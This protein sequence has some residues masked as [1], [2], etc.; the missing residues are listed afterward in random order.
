MI[1]KTFKQFKKIIIA[2]VGGTILL[3]GIA[4]LVLPGPA[5]IVIP[6]GLSILATEFIWAKRIFEKFKEKMNNLKQ[7]VNGNN[8]K[9]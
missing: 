4:M 2:I 1:I 8:K 5:I 7:K 3:I 6:V 9:S